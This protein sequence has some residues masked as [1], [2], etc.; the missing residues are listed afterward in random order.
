MSLFEAQHPPVAGDDKHAHGFCEHND[1]PDDVDG[2]MRL[3]LR[4]ESGSHCAKDG[5][6]ESINEQVESQRKVEFAVSLADRV[7]LERVKGQIPVRYCGGYLL[8]QRHTAP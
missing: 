3:L 1:V 5:R 4:A 8:A 6:T 7:D 2:P